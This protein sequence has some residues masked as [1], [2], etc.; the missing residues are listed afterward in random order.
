MIK[1]NPSVIKVPKEIT[2]SKAVL[3]KYP[4]KEYDSNRDRIESDSS[5]KNRLMEV[6]RDKIGVSSLTVGKFSAAH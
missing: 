4:K 5:P 1:H 3:K 2:Y 6:K